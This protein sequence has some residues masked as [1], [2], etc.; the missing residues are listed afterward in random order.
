LL[1]LRRQLFAIKEG[2]F[3]ITGMSIIAKIKSINVKNILSKI[4]NE[5]IVPTRRIV[6]GAK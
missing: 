5:N 2:Y 6:S 3:W 1:V 4:K